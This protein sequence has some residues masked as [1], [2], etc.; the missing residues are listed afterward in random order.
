MTDFNNNSD[1]IDSRDII[2]RIDELSDYIETG[3]ENGDDVNSERD[4]LITLL[5]LQDECNY[6]DW[7]HGATLINDNYFTEYAQQLADDCYSIEDH[8]PFN[9]I[10]WDYAAEQLQQDYT[11]V[12]FGGAEFWIRS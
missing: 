3:T 7:Q 4:E 11:C 10:N 2:E 8:W 5:T 1:I 12:D 9:C 6:G